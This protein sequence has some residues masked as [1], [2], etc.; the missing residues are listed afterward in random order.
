MRGDLPNLQT[1]TLHF[2]RNRRLERGARDDQTKQEEISG[3]LAR[4][5]SL[6]AESGDGEKRGKEGVIGATHAARG[7][8]LARRSKGI[9]YAF[10]ASGAWQPKRG[11]VRDVRVVLFHIY[12]VKVGAGR[13]CLYSAIR[14]TLSTD[15][16]R[17]GVDAGSGIHQCHSW[18]AV[19][20]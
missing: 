4:Q 13:A 15:E 10:D 16:L 9:Q 8:D 12:L 18:V 5:E 14:S 2:L 17:L 3:T 1:L 20:P 7:L 6:L 19:C 11:R